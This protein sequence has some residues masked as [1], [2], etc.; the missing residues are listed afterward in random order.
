[1][2]SAALEWSDGTYEF[3]AAEHDFEG[4][5]VPGCTLE[6]QLLRFAACSA[7]TAGA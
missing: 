6:T 5:I 2:L 4:V 3:K 1:M 7:S